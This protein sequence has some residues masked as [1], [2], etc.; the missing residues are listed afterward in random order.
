MFLK[1][2]DK[3]VL[4]HIVYVRRQYRILYYNYVCQLN[5][6]QPDTCP[7]AHAKFIEI[8]LAKIMCLYVNVSVHT[9]T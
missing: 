7:L 1:V 8:G 4:I 5:I 9:P 6:F 3:S 2:L